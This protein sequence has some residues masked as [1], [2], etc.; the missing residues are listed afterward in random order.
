MAKPLSCRQRLVRPPIVAFL[1]N[2]DTASDTCISPLLLYLVPLTGRYR[3]FCC[4]SV[5]WLSLCYCLDLG[6]PPHTLLCLHAAQ[7]AKARG[8]YQ[9]VDSGSSMS[10]NHVIER[11]G[12]H[13]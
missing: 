9:Q 8:I 11:I 13:K 4:K 3:P 5:E 2:T 12:E 10:D 1:C 7:V 6:I